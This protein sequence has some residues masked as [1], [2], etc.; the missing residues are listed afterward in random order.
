MMIQG[1]S[2]PGP[3]SSVTRVAQRTGS[4]TSCWIWAILDFTAVPVIGGVSAA[5][6]T[7]SFDLLLSPTGTH[8]RT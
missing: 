6:S 7:P 2:D 5:V 8:I 3:A 4:L 1:D